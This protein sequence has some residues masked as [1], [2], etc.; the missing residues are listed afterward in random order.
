MFRTL[1][2][3][4][5]APLTPDGQRVASQASEMFAIS[6]TPAKR[7]GGEASLSVEQRTATGSEMT[8]G[9]ATTTVN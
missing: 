5:P 9:A 7:R 2:V 4:T 6:F 3:H 8:L 1:R